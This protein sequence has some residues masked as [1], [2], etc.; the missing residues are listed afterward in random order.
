MPPAAPGAPVD[1][2]TGLEYAPLV[3]T[4]GSVN[5]VVFTFTLADVRPA[6]DAVS[7]SV[8]V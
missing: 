2:L 4:T 7:V 3:G 6:A 5:A 1:A 8:P